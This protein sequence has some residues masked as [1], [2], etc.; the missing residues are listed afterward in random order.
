MRGCPSGALGKTRELGLVGD[1]QFEGVCLVEHVLGELRGQLRE[2]DFHRLERCFVSGLELGAMS[3]KVIEGLV[4]ETAAGG[5]ETTSL[6]G[7]RKGLHGL[8]EAV[9]HGELRPECARFGHDG[10]VRVPQRIGRGDA[11][12]MTDGSHRQLERFGRALQ[13][14][15]GVVVRS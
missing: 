6:V 2:L 8:V 5:L 9:V 4:E 14:A 10:V 11:F 13:S 15:E 1:D 12:E 7:L 3:T